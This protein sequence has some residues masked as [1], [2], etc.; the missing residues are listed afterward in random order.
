MIAQLAAPGE[1]VSP[2]KP[3]FALADL[4]SVGVNFDVYEKDAQLIKLGQEVR[5]HT[6][7]DL[8]KTYK[9]KLVFISPRMDETSN[10]LRIKAIVDNEAQSLKLGM[11]VRGE[12]LVKSGD[13]QYLTVPIEAIQ[14]VEGKSVVFVK[15]GADAFEAKEITIIN[16]THESAAIEGDIHPDEQVVVE[17]SF[18]LKSKMLESEMGHG[19]SH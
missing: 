19:H 12:V 11:N 17:G 16:Q 18:I 2:I 8:Q 5:I 4:N 15:E 6:Q 1:K 7:G 14:T 9:G 3:V 10:T 13:T